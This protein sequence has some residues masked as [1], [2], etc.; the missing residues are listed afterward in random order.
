MEGARLRGKPL[1]LRIW[2][3]SDKLFRQAIAEDTGRS[4]EEARKQRV[5]FPRAWSW[6]AYGIAMSYFLGREGSKETLIGE[7]LDLLA[8][9]LE[10]D[11]HDYQN[12]WVAAFIHLVNGDVRRVEHHKREALYLNGEDQNTSVMNEMADVLVWLGRPNDAIK[13]LD[14]T[15]QIS[16]WNRWSM[17]WAF[18]AKGKDDPIFYDW[19]LREIGQTFGRPGDPNYEFDIDLLA[20]AVHAQRAAYFDAI[21]NK[22]KADRERALASSVKERFVRQNAQNGRKDWKIADE[23]RRMPFAENDAAQGLRGHWRDG[24]VKIGLPE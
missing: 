3:E 11:P 10:G 23:M 13:W 6:M 4:F 19:A 2:E 5:G 12:H 16:D 1:T 21:G 15:R 14:R 20:A 18:Y 9:S 24:L 8:I 17:A 22:D 7:A